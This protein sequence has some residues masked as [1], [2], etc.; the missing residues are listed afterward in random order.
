[1]GLYVYN[2]APMDLRNMTEYL[3]EVVARV[4]G[5][6]LAEGILTKLSDD[7]FI[8]G[9]TINELLQNSSK[10]LK[11]LSENNLA[12]STDKSVI[13][14]TAVTVVGWIWQNDRLPVDTQRINPFILCKPPQ[15]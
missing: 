5:D 12:H 7:M 4:L 2:R 13:C 14:P 15:S 1:M 6:C 8:G 9:N 11:K 10:V 3:E